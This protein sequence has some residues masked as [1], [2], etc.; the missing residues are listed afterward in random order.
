MLCESC[1]CAEEAKQRKA[2]GSTSKWC[3]TC[4]RTPCNG[5]SGGSCKAIHAYTM[6]EVAA[7]QV[8][9]SG[10]GK[11]AAQKARLDGFVAQRAEAAVGP[12][13]RTA[14]GINPTATSSSSSSSGIPPA[15]STARDRPT[16]ASSRSSSSPSPAAGA[17]ADA[18]AGTLVWVRQS[19]V[20]KRVYWRPA[21]CRDWAAVGD[22]S[23]TVEVR[24]MIPDRPRTIVKVYR[25][26]GPGRRLILLK[27]F[28]EYFGE[29]AKNSDEW[30]DRGIH[31]EVK[32]S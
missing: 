7:D 23:D 1:F 20:Q 11:K 8:A 10:V 2:N 22:A 5:L 17:P 31:Q 29:M 12:T 30:A 27:T 28:A 3:N 16:S 19:D 21:T 4:H 13:H 25:K 9:Q 15:S 32:H 26:K 6:M 24:W 14:T 18:D